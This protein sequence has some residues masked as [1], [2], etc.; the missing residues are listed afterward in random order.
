MPQLWP[1]KDQKKKKKKK[2]VIT[3]KFLQIFFTQEPCYQ[4][5][6]EIQ[7]FWPWIQYSLLLIKCLRILETIGTTNQNCNGISIHTCQNGYY[8]SFC[9]GAAEMN[10]TRN[11]EVAGSIPCLAQWTKSCGVGCRCSSDPALLWLWHELAAVAQIRL[12]AWEPPYVVGVALK[13]QKKKKRMV[14]IKKTINSECKWE[15]GEKGSIVDS[16]W[17]YKLVHPPWKIV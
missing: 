4:D 1:W 5:R 14:I 13:R 2:R 15:W 8:K 11:Q 12:L 3:D 16:W 17:E 9:C 7:F 10:L 6:S